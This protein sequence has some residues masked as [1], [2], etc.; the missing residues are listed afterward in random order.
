MES[1]G[2]EWILIV[3]FILFFKFILNPFDRWWWNFWNKEDKGDK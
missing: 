3:M 2:N 1:N